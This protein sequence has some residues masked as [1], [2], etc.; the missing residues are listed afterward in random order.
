MSP[1]APRA[2][3]PVTPFT[4][5]TQPVRFAPPR[6]PWRSYVLFLWALLGCSSAR[7]LVPLVLR[8]DTRSVGTIVLDSAALH[9]TL[10]VLQAALP[11]EGAVCLYGELG[12]TTLYGEP[13]LALRIRRAMRAQADSVDRLHVFFPEQPRTGCLPG[14]LVGAAH[15][16][17]Y[18]GEPGP[19]THSD[20]DA[21]VLFTDPR[22]LATLV[23]CGDG[24]GEVLLQ[25]GRRWPMRW[26]PEL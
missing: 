24:R 17:P 8:P 14:G 1:I 4:W 13:R 22:L 10:D 26:R 6:L 15:S 20:P 23:F 21:R 3:P 11:N 19:C 5:N 9:G 7:T 16:H 2:R 18:A 25:D 12:D